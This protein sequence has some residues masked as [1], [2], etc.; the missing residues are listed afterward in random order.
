[1]LYQIRTVHFKEVTGRAVLDWQ[2]TPDNLLYAS[3]SRGYK[4]GGINPPLSPIFTVPEGFKPEFVNAFEVGSK[5][6]FS[7][8]KLQLNV[9]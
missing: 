2:I 6:T 4:S 9:T 1:Q 5:N 8:G 7:N 3:Y